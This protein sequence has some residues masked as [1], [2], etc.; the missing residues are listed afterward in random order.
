MSGSVVPQKIYLEVDANKQCY[1]ITP[2]GTILTSTA[3][4]INTTWSGVAGMVKLI[5]PKASSK[6]IITSSDFSGTFSSSTYSG[7]VEASGM[8]NIGTLICLNANSVSS[9]G[10]SLANLTAPLCTEVYM[11]DS[12]L[13]VKSIADF[14][15]LGAMANNIGVAGTANFDGQYTPTSSQ[16]DA[17]L[18]ANYG[19][20]LLTVTQALAT[21]TITLNA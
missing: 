5:A 14:L 2:T 13:S 9:L 18:I 1:V 6:I 8:Q 19:L 11:S 16:I 20:D 12:N 10:S 7:N 3:G 17:Y 21:W 4:V 15:V